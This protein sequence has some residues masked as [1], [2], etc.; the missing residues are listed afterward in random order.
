MPKL[1]L[2]YFQTLLL[3]FPLGNVL[4]K[5]D[6]TD[7]CAVV[8]GAY[9]KKATQSPGAIWVISSASLET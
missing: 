2:K 7:D 1:V 5:T 8:S 9:F 3:F 6:N 4:S